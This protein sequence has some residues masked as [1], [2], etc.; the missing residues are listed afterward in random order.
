MY[1]LM[2]VQPGHMPYVVK[3]WT[4]LEMLRSDAMKC[5]ILRTKECRQ[6]GRTEIYEH[7]VCDGETPVCREL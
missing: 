3:R 6:G 4:A 1:V 2:T 5:Y 7:Q